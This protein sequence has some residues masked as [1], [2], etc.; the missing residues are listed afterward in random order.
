MERPKDK[1]GNECPMCD[2][3]FLK[4]VVR[5]NWYHGRKSNCRKTIWQR[6]NHCNYNKLI[7]STGKEE[8]I[9]RW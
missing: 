1:I 2:N 8:R 6:C 5:K 9:R 4:R 3:G 7:S